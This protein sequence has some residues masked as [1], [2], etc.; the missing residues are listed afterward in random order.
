ML[1]PIWFTSIYYIYLDAEPYLVYEYIYLD[2]EPYLVYKYVYLDAEPYLVYEFI[3]QT[4]QPGPPVC[5]KCSSK[6]SPPPQIYWTKNGQDLPKS[7]RLELKDSNTYLTLLF[8]NHHILT[9]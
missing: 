3:E 5:L 7:D 1:N 6:G 8:N 4:L 9:T 2:A